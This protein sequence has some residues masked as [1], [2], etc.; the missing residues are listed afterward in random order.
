MSDNGD[1]IVVDSAEGY[2]SLTALRDAHAALLERR[3]AR[4]EGEELLATAEQFIRR[5]V[6]TGSLLDGSEERRAAQSLLNY[7]ANMLYRADRGALDATLAEFDPL[8]APA[9]PDGVCPYLGL[10]AFSEASAERFFG[11]QELIGRMLERL[12]E[13][14]LLAVV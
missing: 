11:R 13:Q 7:W 3:R 1:T 10:D 9:L 2:P 5:G 4:G 14:R 12:G 6:A 8:L